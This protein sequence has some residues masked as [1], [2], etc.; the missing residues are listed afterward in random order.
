[1]LK[2]LFGSG[3]DTKIVQLLERGHIGYLSASCCNPSASVADQQLV[4]NV[5]QALNNLHLPL[6]LQKETLTGAQAS[7]RSAMGQLSLKQSAIAAKIMSLFSTRGLSAFP[8]LFID[9][10]LAFYGGIPT[11]QEIEDYLRAHLDS[12]TPKAA[13]ATEDEPAK[14]A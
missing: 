4:D 7:M 1:M 13:P 9:G 3:P 11:V 10:E 5:Q 2:W 6:E 14:T 8:C 12:L